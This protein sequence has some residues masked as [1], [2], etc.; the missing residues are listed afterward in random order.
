MPFH[1]QKEVGERQKYRRL[2]RL[3]QE[4][5]NNMSSSDSEHH[6]DQ[7][8]NEYEDQLHSNTGEFI[9]ANT[10]QFESVTRCIIFI[11]CFLYR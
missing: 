11:K 5:A 10:M 6:Q 2:N 9:L 7:Q 4:L 8:V 1:P 3:Y